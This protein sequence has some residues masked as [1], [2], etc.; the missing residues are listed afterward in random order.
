MSSARALRPAFASLAAGR[1]LRA[2]LAGV[3][4]PL[5]LAACATTPPASEPALF[6][7]TGFAAPREPLSTDDV[8][9]LSPEMR[10]YLRD[11]IVPLARQHDTRTA[12]TE[13][14]YRRGKLQLE[15]E[16]SLTRNAAEAFEARQGNC[17]SLVIM[18]GAFA[19]ALGLSVVYQQVVTDEM[20]SRSGGL[21]VMSSHVNLTL[22]RQRP[23]LP[24]RYVRGDQ[25]TIDFMP[26]ET[27]HFR[28]R[29]ISEAAVLAMYMN[30]RAVEAMVADK[31]D[32]AYWRVRESLRLDPSFVGAYNTLG[33]VYLRHG[34]V[35]RAERALSRGLALAPDNPR[36][37]ANEAGALEKLGRAAEAQAVREHLARFEATPPF[38]WF[39]RGQAAMRAGDFEG[40]RTL[41]L[42]E[43]D[44]APDY[45]EFH[46]A[47]A[48]ADFNL[49][50]LDEARSE[51]SL[52]LQDAVQH[53]DRDLYAAKLDR[54]RSV[55]RGAAASQ[56]PSPTVQ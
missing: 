51:L 37:L 55:Q 8:F 31:L 17:L 29:P 21:Y 36:L 15:Y 19:K 30:N 44:R 26:G 49:G 48:A 42:K 12:L 46:F 54:L 56:R 6:D 35:A 23:D 53:S 2:A 33:V 7:D 9:G 41:F 13:A 28:A 50:R 18:T 38:Y 43:L 3:A 5:M 24:G 11:T 1:R 22:S 27:P 16:S 40:A 10:V 52:A 25:F 14:L 34:D 47:L 4:L 39:V 20:W 32:D 45:H